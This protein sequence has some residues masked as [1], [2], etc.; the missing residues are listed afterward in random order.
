[1]S[2]VK[3]RADLALNNDFLRK[4]VRFT[5][6]RLRD[7][8]RKAADDHGNWE[9]WRERG[10]QIRLH[11]IA[12]LDYYLNRFAEQP[13]QMGRMFTSPPPARKRFASLWRLRIASR[14]APS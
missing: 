10:R 11:T 9:E 8:K 2:S 14:R 7:G 1:M 4:A 3:E 12:H 6:E 13:G 5:T